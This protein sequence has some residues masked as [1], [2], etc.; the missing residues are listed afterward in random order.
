MTTQPFPDDSKAESCTHC[1]GSESDACGNCNGTGL[2]ED[3]ASCSDCGEW[4][5]NHGTGRYQQCQ[6]CRLAEWEA[7][8]E[9]RAVDA[10]DR[11]YEEAERR[12]DREAALAEDAHE[13]MLEGMR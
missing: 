5:W 10:Y 1:Y 2:G 9:R 3:W 13:R 8:K 4:T 12:A 7:E 6:S 11:A